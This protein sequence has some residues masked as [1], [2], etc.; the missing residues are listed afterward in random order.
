MTK[1]QQHDSG[2]LLHITSLPSTFGIGDLGPASYQF[3]DLLADNKQHYWSILPLSPTRLEDGNSPYQTSSIFAGNTLLISP[4]Q[5]TQDGFLPKLPDK[6]KTNIPKIDFATIYPKKNSMLQEA[7]QNF[8]KTKTQTSEFETFYNQNTHWLD[9]YALYA[10]LRQKT[11][12]P[13]YKWLPSIR[14]REPKTITQKQHQLKDEIESEKFSQYLFFK[15]WHRLKTYC[16]TKQIH[17]IGDMPI[18]TAPDSADTWIHPEL[19]NLY[20]NGKPRYVGGVPPDYF[21]KTGQLWGTPVYNWPNH[22]KTGF[23]FWLNRIK[24]NLSLYDQLRLDHFRGLIA[25]WQVPARAK[26]AKKGRWIKTPSQTFFTA[27]KHTFPAL[28]FIAEDLGYI[29]APV[30]QIIKQLGIPGMRVLLFGLDGSKT[31]PHTPMNYVKNSVAYTGTHDT[32][33]VRGWFTTEANA[34]QRQTLSKLLGK[35]ISKNDV[36]FEAIKLVMSSPAGVCIFPLQDVL[37]L[38]AEARMNNPGYL[39][40]NWQWCV[41]EKQFSTLSFVAR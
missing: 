25:Y 11:N 36:S 5:L 8:K 26:T 19:F 40:G 32:N 2:I 22:K 12:T 6:Q 33:T 35:P 39:F 9:D 17:I 38:G 37:G 34:K 24:H 14:N 21:S 31:N 41:T 3:A 13:W 4:H 18:Y 7:Y 16:N 30:K 20:Q 1:H 28:P 23:T 15:Q 27:L 10:T 29:D